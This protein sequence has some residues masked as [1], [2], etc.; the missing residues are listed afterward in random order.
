MADAI[1]G[2]LEEDRRFPP[3]DGWVSRTG[4]TDEGLRESAADD[5]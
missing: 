3:P 1:E 4:V 5:P 2:L